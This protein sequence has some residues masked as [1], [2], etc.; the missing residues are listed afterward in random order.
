MGVTKEIDRSVL[1]K[2]GHKNKRGEYVDKEVKECAKKIVRLF[3]FLITNIQY[4]NSH[5]CK[6]F[7]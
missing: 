1:W 3:Y 4:N 5:S 6:Y 2:E 7:R